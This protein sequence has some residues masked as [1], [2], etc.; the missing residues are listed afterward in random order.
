[1]PDYKYQAQKEDGKI[2]NGVM[3][4]MMSRISMNV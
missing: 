1:M 4:P 3:V 2:V